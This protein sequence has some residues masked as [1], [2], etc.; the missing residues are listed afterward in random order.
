MSHLVLMLEFNQF[1]RK[2]ASELT[3]IIFFSEHP[4]FT[5]QQQLSSS[6]QE[7]NAKL[8]LFLLWP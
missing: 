5:I 3:G 6:C 2:L 8:G 1:R 7:L 4:L